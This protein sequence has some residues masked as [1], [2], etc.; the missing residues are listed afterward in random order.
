MS[1]DSEKPKLW[2]V[3][4]KY[5]DELEELAESGTPLGFEISKILFDY[6]KLFED[7][8]T[9]KRKADKILRI[10]NNTMET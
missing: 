9:E 10:C 8:L 5:S 7:Y 4:F 3:P 6:G 2:W 1:D